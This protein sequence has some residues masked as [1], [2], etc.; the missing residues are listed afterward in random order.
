VSQRGPKLSEQS[1]GG[2]NYRLLFDRNPQPTWVWDAECLRFLAANE[3]A[4]S[5]YGY[6]QDEFLEVNIEGI[7]PATEAQSLS[8][9]L[10]KSLTGIGQAVVCR[11][12]KKDGT[13]IDAEIRSRPINWAGKPAH[14]IVTSD[15]TG[16]DRTE[17]AFRDS[18]ERV[19]LILASAA[20]AIFGCDPVGTCIFCNDAAAHLLGYDH[21]SELLGK[22]MHTTEHHTRADGTPYPLEECPIYVGFQKGQGIHRD[23]EIFWRKD[24][25]SFPVEYWSHLTVQDGRTL[26]VVTFMDITARKQAE[27]A[28]RKSEELKTRLIASSRDC[29]SVLDIGGQLLSMNEGGMEAREIC[30]LGSV[31]NSS[32]IDF[33]DGDDREAARAAVEVAS[34]GGTSR[35]VGYFA[36]RITKQPKWWDVVVSPIR[37]RKGEPEQLVAVSRDI[38]EHRQ[39]EEALREANIH[40]TRSQERWRAVFENSAIGVALT[41]INGH[42]IAVNRVY[43]K[44]VGYTEEELRKVAFLEIIHEDDTAH[45]LDLL[46]DL[47][48][49]KRKQF[50]IEKQ[51]RR[52]DG[53]LIW[54]RNNVSLVPGTESMPQFLMA[55]SEDITERKRAEE[56]LRR[57]EERARTLLEINN[58]VITNL[59]QE[60][61]LHSISD[62]LHS[63]I[64]FDRCAI[65]IYQ[66]ERDTF[67]FLAVEGD[68]HSDYFRAGLED[69]RDQTC[70]GWVFDHQ[71]PLLRHDLKKE[72]Q[73]ANERRLVAEGIQSMCAFPLVFQ[74]K[75][76]GTLSLVSRERDRYSDEDAVFLQEVA[77]QV[78]LAI[79]NMQSYEEIDSLKARL[80]KEN[81]YLQEEIRTE[82]NFEEIVGNSPRASGGPPKG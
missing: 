25:T 12:Q 82:H 60:T 35:F 22:N 61:L 26:C 15:I 79:Q 42:F 37:G 78:V 55:L 49:E 72:G 75:C 13:L 39:N 63:V 7:Q 17:Q 40:V 33:W 6:S 23:D 36:T 71:R 66:P 31:V 64:S 46:T 38:T 32:W 41:D 52:K 4:I 14:L 57:S 65:T 29:I 48:E 67:L 73:Y 21:F 50:Q 68:L 27:E 11:F 20:E 62:A 56:A 47:L 53:S 54:V 9:F 44:M 10:S 77:N 24:G 43:E 30:D 45:N 2:D 5:H 3:A 69:S 81:V 70:A 51:Y 18:E 76:I 16:R 59:D 1:D 74:G 34:R 80:E 28:L 8:K 58:A 19:R